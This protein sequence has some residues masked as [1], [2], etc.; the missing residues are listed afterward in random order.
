MNVLSESAT[1]SVVILESMQVSFILDQ[2]AFCSAKSKDP[3]AAQT[4]VV[5]DLALVG[6]S[7]VL[8]TSVDLC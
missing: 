3:K 1:V 4:I 2:R 8:V 6:R 5:L 7:T